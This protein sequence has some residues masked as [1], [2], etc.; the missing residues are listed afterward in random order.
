[1]LCITCSKLSIMYANKNCMKCQSLVNQSISILCENCS[2]REKV[3]SA[4]L[5][6]IYTTTTTIG[7]RNNSGCGCGKSK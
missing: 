4:C 6:K 5:K 2:L 3:C 1:M 7:R